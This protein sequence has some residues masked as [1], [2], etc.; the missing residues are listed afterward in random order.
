MR[1]AV[2]QAGLSHAFEIDSAGTH[3]YHPA[4]APDER[5]QQHA[6]A[7]GYDLSTLRAR[8]ITEADFSYFDLVLTMDW[9]NQS[10]AEHACPAPHRQK[11]RRFAE[12]FQART[13]TVVPDPYFGGDSGFEHVLDLCEDGVQG[14]LAYQRN[15]GQA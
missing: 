13:D 14:L 11:I 15:L 5:S 1:H 9:D 8:Q 2:S 7:R 10:L 6:M 12:F 4:A 3:N